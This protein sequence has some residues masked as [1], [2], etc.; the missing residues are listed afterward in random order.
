MRAARRFWP[1]ASFGLGLFGLAFHARPLQPEFRLVIYG[2]TNG[3]LAPCGCTSP[4]SG[5][6]ARAA[7]AISEL[8]RADPGHT[9]FVLEG[10][11]VAGVGR[12]DELK[13][14][15]YAEAAG[16]ENAKAL[17]FSKEEAALGQGLELEM[18]SLSNG[19]LLQ[20]EIDANAPNL[21]Q[22]VTRSGRFVLG[23]V[24]SEPIKIG[25]PL[26]VSI[27]P[28]SEAIGYLIS[29]CEGSDL[30]ILFIDGGEAAARRLAGTYPR[31][32]VIVFRST[33]DPLIQ[34]IRVGNTCLITAGFHGK[35]VVEIGFNNGEE[36]EYSAVNLGPDVSDDPSVS[37]IYDNYLR[38]I[39]EEH[40]LADLPRYS[41][42][43]YAGS[44]SC[45]NCH[46][47]AY[48]VWFAS[49]HSHAYADLGIV[50]GMALTLSLKSQASSFEHRVLALVAAPCKVLWRRS[51]T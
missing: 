49:G 9:T 11:L 50:L 46:V 25:Q 7:T 1:L 6:I 26:G 20:S 51:K 36:A 24:S 27:R 34:P 39:G 30:P 4:M 48:R 31:L 18:S 17:A 13:A 38:R 29:Q 12:Q 44:K 16:A 8:E 35:N 41:K 15:C 33:T 21:P 42:A 45:A 23:A 40:L 3:Y 5:G 2:D 10:G 37:R 14:E 22:R 28:E 19:V 47:V 43:E 32:R